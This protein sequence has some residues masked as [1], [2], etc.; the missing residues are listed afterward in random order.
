MRAAIYARYSS[1][2]QREASIEDQLEVCRRYAEV[3]SWPVVKAYI[4]YAQ[5]GASRFRSGFQQLQVDASARKFD[6]VLGEA[7]DRFSRKLADVADLHD[8]LTFLGIRLHTV[9][10]GEVTAMHVGLLG[11]MAQIYL[12]DLAE[13]TRRGQLGRALKG[14]V[15]GG[16]AYGYDVLPAGADGA[17][18]RRI[19]PSE[20]ATVRCIFELFA[21]GVSPREIAK[22]LNAEGVPGP[23]GREWRDTTMRGQPDRGTGILNNALYAGRLEWNRCSYVK[24]PRTGKRVARP[25][26]RERWEM[27]SVP[28][29]RVVS[30]ELWDAVK[31]RQAEVRIAMT[32]QGDGNALNGAHRRKYLLSGLLRCGVCGGGYTIIN[33]HEYGCGRHRS[34]GTCSNGHRVRRKTLERRVLNGLKHRLLAPEMVKEFARAYQE[35][36]N[37]LAVEITQR[38]AGDEG[39]LEAVRH[40][41]AC[42]LRAIEDGLYQPSMKARMA[43]HEAEKAALEERLAV[44]PE[45]PKGRLHPNMAGLYRHRVAALEEAL[46]DPAVSA[47][48]MELVRRQIDRITLTPGAD[49]GLEVLLHGDLPRILIR[50]S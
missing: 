13:K 23:D 14:R 17:G 42:M 8:R 4:D 38:R 34:K 7:L 48:V 45:P 21:A 24:H 16:K 9:S 1:D 41:I 44:A 19:N 43:E 27:V 22:R 26:P 5:S 39:R 49:G 25:N 15:P 36:T 12:E 30:D 28:E 50:C 33:A 40:K 18:E 47:K 37:R 32:C 2:N 31:A 10:T 46:V 20:A 29:L 3:K 11:T 6:I 35:E